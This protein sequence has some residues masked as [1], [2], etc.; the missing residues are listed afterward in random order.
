MYELKR[1]SLKLLGGELIIGSYNLYIRISLIFQCDV[2]HVYNYKT[3]VLNNYKIMWCTFMSPLFPGGR[4]CSFSPC[5]EQVQRTCETLEKLGFLDIQTLECLN[6]TFDVR[7]VNMPVANL[8]GGDV[9]IG[10][11][12]SGSLHQPITGHIEYDVVGSKDVKK[13]KWFGD[14][15]DESGSSDQC[16][17]RTVTDAVDSSGVVGESRTASFV[18]KTAHPPVTM[19]GHTGFLTFATL[20]PE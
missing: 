7:T 9:D 6:R 15:R 17:A 5:I 1:I 19:Q 13:K 16:S 10:I 14:R 4:I 2:E 12:H 11:D 18:F 3:G 8:G 20:Y